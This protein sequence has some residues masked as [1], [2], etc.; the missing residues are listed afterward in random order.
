[1]IRSER[2]FDTIAIVV[3]FGL[4]IARCCSLPATDIAPKLH[5]A[6]QN[7]TELFA[8]PAE[9]SAVESKQNARN[10]TPIYIPKQCAENEILYPGDHENDWVCDCK[11][12]YV[13]HP[14]TQ[15]CYQMYTKGYCPA[16]NVIY[17]EPK[18]KTPVCLP[19]QCPDGTVRFMNVCAVLNKEHALCHLANLRMV[20]GINEDTH[21]LECVNI[22]DVA[23][24]RT[25]INNSN[26]TRE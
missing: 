2:I 13:Y 7:R 18:G 14:Q 4:L 11:P 9:Q 1:M 25:L 22:S 20:V 3:C 6:Q 17:I 5:N 15:Q 24:N 16:G 10:R 8:Y 19:N 12:T 23:F 21:E 26:N